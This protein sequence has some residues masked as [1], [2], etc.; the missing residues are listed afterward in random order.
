MSP[1]LGGFAGLVMVSTLMWDHQGRP[2]LLCREKQ[3][4]IT[5][6]HLLPWKPQKSWGFHESSWL[7]SIKLVLLSLQW[8]LSS[9]WTLTLS[10]GCSPNLLSLLYFLCDYSWQNIS[11]AGTR[12]CSMTLIKGKWNFSGTLKTKGIFSSMSFYES[13]LTSSDAMKGRI[14]FPIFMQKIAEAEIE[15]R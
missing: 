13:Q 11:L 3:W 9:R 4:Q 5:F 12:I 8:W 10:E 1:E 7:G 14:M 2:G 15:Q 6:A